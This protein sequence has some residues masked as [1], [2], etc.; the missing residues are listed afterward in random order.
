MDIRDRIVGL[1]R[2]KA[3][4]LVPNARNWRTHPEFQRDALKG[5]LAEIGFAAPL[6]ARQREDG[7]LVLIDGHLRAETVPDM[8]VPVVVLDVTAAEADKLL[9]TLDPMAALAGRDDANL[10]AL[11]DEVEF[12]SQAVQKMLEGL[13][14]PEMQELPP[15]GQ[16]DPDDVPEPPAESWVKPGDL[17]A[18]ANHRLLCGDCT[19]PEDVDRLMDGALADMCWTDPPWNVAYGE[20]TNPAGW[21][22][23][24][25]PIANDN[26]GEAFPGFCTAFCGEIA[27]V[28]KPG[29][30]LYM[31]MSAQEW[32]T[33]HGALTGMGFHWSSTI[34]WAKDSLV[35]SRKDYHTQ[36]EPI[37]Y[38]WREGSARLVEL[39]DRTQSDLWQ[40]PRPKRSAEHPTMKPVELVARSLKNS[41]K[42]FDLILEPFSGSGTTLLAA[43]QTMRRCYAIEL[44]PRYVQVAIERWEAFT[45]MKAKK[46]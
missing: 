40:I 20:N 21:S 9:L 5:V 28:V 37:W 39:E 13:G 16:T 17:F 46:L 42:Q 4:Q 27:R 1:K 33:I 8:E 12:E 38:G 35:L 26:L 30:P 3:S 31:A 36:Y 11:L 7:K 14:G 19:K 10:K 44:E 22:G 23:K 34:I 2:V 18:L 6:I 43:E 45:G 32:P 29:A 24:H 15:A 25:R 41:S